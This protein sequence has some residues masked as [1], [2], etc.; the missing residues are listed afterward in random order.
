MS[1][2]F[3]LVTAARVTQS[4]STSE[5]AGIK[6]L[7]RGTSLVEFARAYFQ[8]LSKTGVELIERNNMITG[9]VLSEDTVS[10]W[11]FTQYPEIEL[12]DAVRHLKREE[13]LR[14][15]GELLPLKEMTK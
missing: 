9:I 4:G 3:V 1:R 7:K 13:L 2:N 14:D 5:S 12:L 10:T 15:L 6:K 8:V 11:N